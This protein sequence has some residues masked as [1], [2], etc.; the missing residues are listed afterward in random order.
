L[1]TDLLIKRSGYRLKASAAKEDLD[2]ALEELAVS[3]ARGELQFDGITEW[4]K[5]RLISQ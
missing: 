2:L 3:V 1:L 5:R 4:F